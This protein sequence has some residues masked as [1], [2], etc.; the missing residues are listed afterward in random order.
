MG[1]FEDY[2]MFSDVRIN[3]SYRKQLP[4]HLL[5]KARFIIRHAE[6][7]RLKTVYFKGLTSSYEHSRYATRYV[8]NAERFYL[9]IY[10]HHMNIQNVRKNAPPL[11][12]KTLLEFNRDYSLLSHNAVKEFV[13]LGEY[14]GHI[15]RLADPP[16]KRARIIAP[17]PEGTELLKSILV[18]QSSPVIETIGGPVPMELFQDDAFIEELIGQAAEKIEQTRAIYQLFPDIEY[19]LV[20]RTSAYPIA[21]KLLSLAQTGVKNDKVDFAFHHQANTFLVSRNHIRNIID[22]M[23]DRG[24]VVQ[25]QKGGREIQI[26]RRL[27]N[28]MNCF[29]AVRFAFQLTALISALS[30]YQAQHSVAV[31][32]QTSA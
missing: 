32:T 20:Q 4:D 8:G 2:C 17:T 15:Q 30:A 7:A 28:T 1:I 23:E 24:L 12:L 29:I 9:Q 21:I 3:L 11:T 14:A 6:F 31:R 5:N 16:D 19:L 26:L 25:T 22:E 18:A 27:T 13:A 10:I